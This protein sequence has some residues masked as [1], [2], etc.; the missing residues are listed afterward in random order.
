MPKKFKGD[1]IDESMNFLRS[2]LRRERMRR[3]WSQKKLA[4]KI[5]IS[6]PYLSQLENADRHIYWE[7]FVAWCG[8]LRMT[9]S[10]VVDKWQRIGGFDGFD[11][12]QIKE[13]HEVVDNMIAFDFR[14][15]LDNF[16]F[17]FK[18]LVA[19]ERMAREKEAEKKKLSDLFR[20]KEEEKEE[21]REND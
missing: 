11:K 14:T 10:Y 19:Q 1:G 3:G 6:E 15:E 12:E 16:M 4:K 20:K 18:G 17:Y 2:M 9:P 8:A 7:L 5:G 21:E 13:Y